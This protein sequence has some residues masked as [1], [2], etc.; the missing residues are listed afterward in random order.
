MALSVRQEKF[1]VEYAKS[2]NAAESYKKAGYK[3]KNVES[4]TACASRL[5]RNANVEARLAELREET[6]R[7]SI[8]DIGEIQEILTS[9]ARGETR[10]EQIV[11]EGCGDGISQGVIKTRKVQERDRLKAAELLAKMRGGFDNTI[12]VNLAVPKFS[13]DDEL[14]D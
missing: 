10:E 8:A 12:N 6:K 1:C 14:E 4:A 13:G 9:I 7:D 3:V 5:L 2:G 11:V